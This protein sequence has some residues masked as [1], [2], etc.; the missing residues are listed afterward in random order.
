VEL[1]EFDGEMTQMRRILAVIFSK[2]RASQ[3]SD[4]LTD[5]ESEYDEA[6]GGCWVDL[7]PA[8]EIAR[9]GPEKYVLLGF[10]RHVEKEW[11]EILNFQ[12]W[13]FAWPY[14]PSLLLVPKTEPLNLGW[15]GSVDYSLISMR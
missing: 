12:F 14:M 8:K 3:T 11:E 15:G 1:K 13:N 6:A 10:H 7:E 9:M 4:G 2:T 5:F